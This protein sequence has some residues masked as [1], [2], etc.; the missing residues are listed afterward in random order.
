M[1]QYSLIRYCTTSSIAGENHSTKEYIIKIF[2]TCMA[3]ADLVHIFSFLNYHWT[4]DSS[5]NLSSIGNLYLSTGLFTAR[6][7]FL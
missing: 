5:L 2:V 4:Y 3:I 6:I 7:I 1:I